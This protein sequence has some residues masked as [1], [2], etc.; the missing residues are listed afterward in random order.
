ML[1]TSDILAGIWQ[2]LALPE[3][4]PKS[5][6]VIGGLRGIGLLRPRLSIED[7]ESQLYLADEVT[8]EDL[9]AQWRRWRDLR[10]GR[11]LAWASFEH[12]CSLHTLAN[13]RGAVDMSELPT[14][15]PCMESLWQASSA[16][17]WKALFIQSSSIARGPPLA[18]LLQELFSSGSFPPDLT[19]L[20]KASVLPGR[21]GGTRIR[22]TSKLT[23]V[24]KEASSLA[25]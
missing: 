10:Q 9:Q 23:P 21:S 8:A 1:P 17:A 16:A 25:R 5:W 18:G 24:V 14:H 6:H 11:R 4:G 2:S 3:G 7:D 20:A 22:L 15:L 19:S 13:R 12:D